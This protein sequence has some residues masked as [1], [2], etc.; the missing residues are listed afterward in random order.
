MDVE[1]G[2]ASETQDNHKRPRQVEASASSQIDVMESFIDVRK[3]S[4]FSTLF[5]WFRQ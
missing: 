3:G 1:E 2:E 4:N 5:S